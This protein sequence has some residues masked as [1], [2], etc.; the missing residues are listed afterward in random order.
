MAT[1]LNTRIILR[2]D[3][4]NNWETV[5][6]TVVLLKG[7]MGIEFNPDATTAG[8]K[9]KVK[10][11][12]GTHSWSQLPYFGGEDARVFEAT[13]ANGGDHIAALTTAVGDTEPNTHDVGIVKEL[14]ADGKYKHTA[15]RY[16]GT[17]WTAMDGNYNAENVYFDEDFV[18]TKPVGTVT[19]PA[20]GSKT[21]AA[22]GKSVKDFFA[23]LF[24]AEQ[25][26][27]KTEPSVNVTLTGAGSY[28]VGSVVNP[29][30]NATFEDGVYTYG[31]EPTGV[32][33]SAW[34][35]TSTANETFDTASG[36]CAPVTV[37]DGTNYSVTAKATHSAGAKAKTNI[38]NESSV[39]IAAGTKSKKSNAITGY[40]S[41]FYGVL[42][43]SSAEAPLT[44][45]IV[46]GMTNGGAY[47]ASK[48]FTLNGSATAKRI[49]IAIPT[50]STRA[51]LKEVILTSAM[52]TPVT[53]SYV[54]TTAAVK[55]EGKNGATAIDYNVWVYEPAAIDAGE[56]HKITLA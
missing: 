37:A 27:T 7:E 11:G 22:A 36:T 20:S 14:I 47:N 24:A 41:F 21:V 5:K 42:A 48:T 19:I 39:Q 50:N 32:T 43:T 54:K 55:V 40:R 52:N 23:G 38:G 29:S 46:R 35:V 1:S 12:D 2:N 31:P 33:V 4:T 26:P 18:F 3:S 6:D 34:E 56:V 51:G 10:I 30:Y 17:S 45:E 44:S 28:E 53:D 15:Y 49:V 9:T 13:V 16:N 8:M 25:D